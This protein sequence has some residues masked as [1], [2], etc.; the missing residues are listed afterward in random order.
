MLRIGHRGNASVAVENSVDAFR[1][2]MRI[3]ADGIELDVRL[4]KDNALVASHD[5]TA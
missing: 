2:A 1:S 4:T 5:P 3:G